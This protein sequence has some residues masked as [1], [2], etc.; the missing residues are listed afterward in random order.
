M[1]AGVFAFQVT[2]PESPASQAEGFGVGSSGVYIHNT[3][4]HYP[5]LAQLSPFCQVYKD[6]ARTEVGYANLQKRCKAGPHIMTWLLLFPNKSLGLVRW[7]GAVWVLHLVP[8]TNHRPRALTVV[9]QLLLQ[10]ANKF[11][12]LSYN[13][14][15]LQGT[16]LF[17]PVWQPH[18]LPVKAEHCPLGSLPLSQNQVSPGHPNSVP[19]Q[20]SEVFA[21]PRTPPGDSLG[22]LIQLSLDSSAAFTGPTV[23][24]W[25]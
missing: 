20:A 2:C 13:L 14:N 23:P 18:C 17:P 6:Q 25:S 3:I 10:V 5:G 16:R 1:N 19:V 8:S 12:A 11:R 9:S 7:G 15:G 4:L 21:S 22:R 24:S